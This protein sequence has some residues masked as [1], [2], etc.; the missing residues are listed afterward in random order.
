MPDSGPVDR[1]GAHG[2]G[3]GVGIE[4]AVGQKRRIVVLR[5]QLHEVHLGM[6]GHVAAAENAV[7][8]AK[9]DLA[10]LHQHRAK[11]LVSMVDGGL[12]ECN[13]LAQQRSLIIHA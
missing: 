8:C 1:S 13:R 7:F 12:R 6:V 10:V 3:F 4:R 2:A 11:R 5:G 9:D